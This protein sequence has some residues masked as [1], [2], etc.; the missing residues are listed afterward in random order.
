MIGENYLLKY[1]NRDKTDVF[2]AGWMK[3]I[4]MKYGKYL[5]SDLTQLIL[6]YYDW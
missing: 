5:S 3:G 6:E 4:Q 1:K 2:I